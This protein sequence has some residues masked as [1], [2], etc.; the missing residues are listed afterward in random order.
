MGDCVGL[1]V[2]VGD[3]DGVA[4]ASLAVPCGTGTPSGSVEVDDDLGIV[5][6][7]ETASSGADGP[8]ALLSVD[9][10]MLGGCDSDE[11]QRAEN[12]LDGVLGYCGTVIHKVVLSEGIYDFFVGGESAYENPIDM[13]DPSSYDF[14]PSP[15]DERP[16]TPLEVAP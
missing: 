11:R 1:A 2:G 5:M 16:T 9:D 3:G 13:S 12:P 4:V 14:I 15:E 7:V 10:E 6:L 8:P